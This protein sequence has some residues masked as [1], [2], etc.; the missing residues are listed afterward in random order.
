VLPG[1]RAVPASGASFASPTFTGPSTFTGQI[2]ASDGTGP[3]PA[4]AF[5]SEPSLG[6]YR[7]GA[8]SIVISGTMTVTGNFSANL[9]GVSGSTYM[10]APAS[11]HLIVENAGLVI[12][13]RLKVDALP[14]IASGFGTSPAVTAGSTPLAGSVNVGTGGVAVS[15][16]INWNG[17]AFPS[18][19]FVTCMN[20]TTA[21]VLRCVGTTTQL[22]ITAPA[23]FVA[24][25]IV[26][27]Q[28]ISSK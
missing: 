23:A 17:T 22:T 13:V 16:V 6:W 25:D 14:T 1:A 20:S 7:S 24:S 10:A 9:V 28:A 11:G 4:Y 18:A 12:G 15:G 19:P 2:L 26:V 8:G 3:L 27:W 21:A 5:A